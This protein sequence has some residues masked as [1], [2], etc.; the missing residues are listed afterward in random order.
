MSDETPTSDSLVPVMRRGPWAWA[1]FT[2]LLVV[3]V[4]G[5]QVWAQPQVDL[6][7]RFLH[8]V[9]EGRLDAAEAITDSE[10]RDE[11]QALRRGAGDPGAFALLRASLTVDVDWN[12]TV[13]Y[14]AR[15][16]E[17]SL[18]DASGQRHNL[19][20]AMGER[21]EGWRVERVLLQRPNS[22]PCNND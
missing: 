8:D 18:R 21:P 3:V 13:S 2:A 1:G 19:Y 12:T 14:G 6:A 20:V 4:G 9:R 10:A 11:L 17:G 15:C 7:S 16:V 5:S 22:G